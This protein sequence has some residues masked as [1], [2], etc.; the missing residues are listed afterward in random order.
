MDMDKIVG[1]IISI[2]I[3]IFSGYWAYQGYFEYGFWDGTAPG[4]G[5]LP[6]TMGLI[7]FIMTLVGLF[8][9]AKAA[10]PVSRKNFTPLW[11]AVVLILAVKIFGMILSTGLFLIIWLYYL[12]KFTIK[13]S[14]IISISTTVIIWF[15]FR[16]ILNVPFPTGF[17]GF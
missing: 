15:L 10:H 7:V 14:A 1:R 9:K 12:E 6:V 5:F 4:A 13:K 3:L 16:F 8:K 2:G 11:G 17:V